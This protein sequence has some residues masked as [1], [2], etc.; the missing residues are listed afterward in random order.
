MAE[1]T[2]VR[3]ALLVMARV[4][5]GFGASMAAAHRGRVL[6]AARAIAGG[7]GGPDPASVAAAYARAYSGG[8]SID[9]PTVRHAAALIY[10]LG[11][12]A[13]V[14]RANGGDSP[15]YNYHDL[16][17]E[18]LVLEKA[19]PRGPEVRLGFSEVDEQAIRELASGFFFWVGDD[20]TEEMQEVIRRKVVELQLR[21]GLSS[22]E[23]GAAII[24]A[25][26]AELLGPTRTTVGP[27]GWR[28]SM[29][30]YYTGVAA[31]VATV[32]RVAGSLAAFA[33]AGAPR[34]MIVNPD[35]ERTCPRCKLMDGLTFS[36]EA[37]QAQVARMRAATSREEMKQAQPWYSPAEFVRIASGRSESE[38]IEARIVLPSYHL[39]CRCTVDVAPGPA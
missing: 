7:A 2:T 36:L 26:D 11:K 32:A 39:L 13:A 1:I 28:G 37:G 10:R 27:R 4:E 21:R 24:A 22:R 20:H 15:V 14:L 8:P 31:N 17:A 29:L 30:E 33:D 18:E 6:A 25:L 9:S 3:E 23:V 38:L 19:G 12:A 35:D 16:L 5:L 34:F